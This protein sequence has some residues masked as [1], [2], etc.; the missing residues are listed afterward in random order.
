VEETNIH[1]HMLPTT[2]DVGI[3]AICET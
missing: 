3:G 2:Y 1:P